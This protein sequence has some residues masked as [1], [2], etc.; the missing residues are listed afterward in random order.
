V[1]FFLLSCICENQDSEKLSKFLLIN[2]SRNR[3][4]NL[5]ILHASYHSL[6]FLLMIEQSFLLAVLEFELRALCLLIGHSSTWAIPLALFALIILEI[7]SYGSFYF[8][9][10]AVAGMSSMCHHTWLLTEMES[11]KLFPQAVVELQFFRSQ[12]PK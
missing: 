5:L 3:T 1:F 8:I 6:V 7:V 12:P 4:T 2:N 11:C 9:L 10:L